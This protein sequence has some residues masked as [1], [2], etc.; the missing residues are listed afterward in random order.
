V[1]FQ[2]T[3]RAWRRA[4]ADG[5]ISKLNMQ[6][7]DVRFRIN[8][9]G[10]NAQLF[11]GTNDA[12]RDLAPIS[13]QNFLEHMGRATRRVTSTNPKQHLTELHWLAVF[14][15]HF[16]DDAARFGFDF[17]HYFHRLDN[18]NYR[19]LSNRLPNIDKGRSVR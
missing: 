18:A 8:S 1:D 14:S 5:F 10:A 2:V 6:R 9:Q 12:Q 11:T 7:I 19:V 17:V 13:N 3:F 4:D 15:N 16:G